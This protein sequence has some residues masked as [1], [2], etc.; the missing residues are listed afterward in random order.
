MDVAFIR[1]QMASHAE[2]I[3]G[4]VT[5]CSKEQASWKPSE[6]S[7]SML[8]VVNHV[9]DEERED[10]RRRIEIVL[11]RPEEGWFR[12]NPEKAASE[13]HYNER[14]LEES[15]KAFLAAR[16]ESLR[17]LD[18]LGDVDWSTPQ[19]APFGEI[20]AGDFL[21]SWVAHDVLHMR[22]IVRLKWAYLTERLEP[23]STLYAGE[24]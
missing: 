13:R 19:Q 3:R 15:L 11:Q 12:F 14:D 9:L 7:W 21:A 1:H 17:W 24:W 6:T 16:A 18:E 22:Q 8:E 5:G 23:Y 2:A 20:R 10:F 4:L